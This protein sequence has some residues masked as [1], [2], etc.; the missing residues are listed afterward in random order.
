VISLGMVTGGALLRLHRTDPGAP[1]PTDLLIAHLILPSRMTAGHHI[2][3][4]LVATNHG[5]TAIPPGRE[6][7]A[8]FRVDGAEVSWSGRVRRSLAAGE[9]ITLD[10]YRGGFKDGGRWIAVAGTHTLEATVSD[11]PRPS[12]TRAVISA[13]NTSF[14]VAPGLTKPVNIVHP[15]ITGRAKVG[16][17]LRVRPGI[18]S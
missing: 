14:H 10:A 12:G 16:H 2:R 8:H 1:A 3:F 15:R 4:G 17:R 13:K 11:R 9:S 18:W 6:L 7:R 5:T